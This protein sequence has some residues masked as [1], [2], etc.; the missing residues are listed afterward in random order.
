MVPAALAATALPSNAQAATARVQND[1]LIYTAAAGE[2]NDTRVAFTGLHIL[3]D[4]RV[5]ITA[6]NGCVIDADGRAVCVP[7]SG[8][9]K[10][11]LGDG[12]DKMLYQPPHA[13]E[14]DLGTFDDII[15]AGAQDFSVNPPVGV[16]PLDIRGGAGRDTVSYDLSGATTVS[17]DNLPNDGPIGVDE[18]VRTDIEHV[19]GSKGRDT[20]TGSNDPNR[21]DL[22]TGGLGD[23]RIDGLGGNDIFLEGA[24]ANGSDT[25]NGGS[26]IDLVDYSKRTKPLTVN[27]DLARN[28]GE[29]GERDFLD[30]NVNDIFGGSAADEITGGS[31]A[32][33]FRGFAGGDT[34]IGLGGNDNLDGGTGVDTLKG[35]AAD[36]VLDAVDNTPDTLRCESGQD[37]LN[38]DLQDV[39]ATNCEIVNSVGTL[40]LAPK[41]LVA[42]ADAPAELQM[43]WT[44]PRSWRSLR[45]LEVQLVRDRET[46]GEIVIRPRG[47][48]IS[49]EGAVTLARGSLVRKGKTVE[50]RL[51]VELDE[52]LGGDPLSIDVAATD[53]R[54]RTQVQH[55]A[56]TLR[57]A[58]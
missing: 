9:A 20:I 13:A 38:R 27:L 32:N 30:P 8:T 45:K 29:A 21:R 41:A 12:E 26:G 35:G 58:R 18:N 31:G 1:A 36:D 39:D 42:K 5:P 44:H 48:R 54:G 47:E 15:Q 2:V 46:V 53:T 25:Y 57:V 50:A 51:S 16:Q 19:I 14:V 55:D 6:G 49:D 33:V 37:T 10:Y 43:S 7:G 56:G 23:D 11:Q 4:D 22:F 34:L 3:I 40:E 24:V 52:Q 17:L 28:D